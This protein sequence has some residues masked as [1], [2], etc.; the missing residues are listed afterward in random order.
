MNPIALARPGRAAGFLLAVLAFAAFSAAGAVPAVAQV[1]KPWVPQGDSLLRDVT[2]ARMRFQRQRGDSIGG[3]NYLPYD[4]VGRLA[5]KLLRSLG[6]EHVLQA[7]AIEATLDS[8]GLD[9]EITTD[10]AT[11]GVVLVLVHN[12]FRA[13]SGAVGFLLWYARDDLRMQGVSFPP[14]REPRMRA[15]YT[16]RS[17]SPYEACVLYIGKGASFRPGMKLF[18]MS[19]D[20]RYWNMVQYEGEGPEFGARA[21]LEFVDVNHDGRPEILAYHPVD[22]DS[23]FVLRSGVPPIVNEFL[24]TERPEGFVLHDAR[25]VP[26]PT[27]TLRLFAALVAEKA[28][29]RA[30]RLLLTP[31]K[32]S[33][34][35]ANGWAQPRGRDAWIVEYGEQGQPWPEWLEA[36]TL[37]ASGPKRWIFHFFIQDGRWVIRDWLPVREKPP[38]GAPADSAAARKP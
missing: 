30:K 27:E 38:A 4:D 5:R 22:E 36:R 20:G 10:P 24:Y 6:R 7:P 19:A 15:W 12:P 17:E 11:P 13:S 26:G 2:T 3:D 8:L 9:T 21:S 28:F 34:V 35:V 1:T 29:D 37:S 16:G 23:A 25:T 18:R 14:S 31:E 32:I 33:E